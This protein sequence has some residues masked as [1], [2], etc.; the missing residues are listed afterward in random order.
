MIPLLRLSSEFRFDFSQGAPIS[1]LALP[2]YRFV[3]NYL[4]ETLPRKAG[5]STSLL[6]YCSCPLLFFS[7]AF[8]RGHNAYL[9][10]RHSMFWVLISRT[11]LI[12]NSHERSLNPESR[13]LYLMKRLALYLLR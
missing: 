6:D 4:V 3:T 7:G 9:S 1:S 10:E 8:V 2:F 13:R 12:V 5:S 11:F